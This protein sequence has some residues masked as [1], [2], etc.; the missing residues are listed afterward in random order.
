M[1]PMLRALLAAGLM[2]SGV[3]MAQAEQP[4]P[5]EQLQ[6]QHGPAKV[7]IGPRASMA[8]PEGYRFL[9]AAETRKFMELT[10]NIPSDE[11][12]LLAPE[13]MEWWTAF[14][15]AETG[16]VKD[17]ETLDPAD[18]LA[19]I[20]EGTELSNEERRKRGWETM[21]VTG[22]RFEPRYDKSTQLLEW[23]INAVNDADNAPII[24]YNTRLLGRKGVMEVVLVANPD[25]LDTAVSQLKTTL[26]GF[27]YNPGETY[28]EYREG[29]H[30]A[31]Y[32]LAALVAGGAAA[33]ITKKGLW[34]VIAAFFLKFWKL[35]LMAVAGI[36]M[37]FKKRLG[38]GDKE[39]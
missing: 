24:N 31:E 6:W 18:L 9:N 4:D 2:F 33:V 7:A 29:D 25:G 13:N 10:Q 39:K 38:G 5:I 35:V 1:L 14:T 37:F 8:L 20:K 12:Y 34:P 3:L 36:G 19:S 26:K 22:W 11:E 17:D 15:F 28:A 21:S 32:G 30:V 27:S 23:A 16:Y